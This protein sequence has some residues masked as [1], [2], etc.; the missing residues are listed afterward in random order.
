MKG[1]GRKSQKAPA[2][3]RADIFS[4]WAAFPEQSS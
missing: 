3:A 4:G 1:G 2:E